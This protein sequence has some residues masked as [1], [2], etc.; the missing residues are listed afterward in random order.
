M[1][2][3]RAGARRSVAPVLTARGSRAEI[4]DRLIKEN[5][6][7]K[8]GGAVPGSPRGGTSPRAAVSPRA[9]ATPEKP[10]TA[11]SP[12]KKPAPLSASSAASNPPS[13]R[14]Q[15]GNAI[16]SLVSQQ[17]QTLSHVV[18]RVEQF[19]RAEQELLKEKE[20]LRQQVSDLSSQVGTEEAKRVEAQQKALAVQKELADKTVS[21]DSARAEW[22]A[23]KTALT[24]K[25]NAVLQKYAQK[26]K[27]LQTAT[28]EASQHRQRADEATAKLATLERGVKVLEGQK[29]EEDQKYKSLVAELEQRQLT[30]DAATARTAALEKEFQERLAAQ[31]QEAGQKE[32]GQ[33]R[34]IGEAE[35]ALATAQEEQRRLATALATAEQELAKLKAQPPVTDETQLK[36]LRR[37]DRENKKH[38]A[39]VVNKTMQVLG[40]IIERTSGGSSPLAEPRLRDTQRASAAADRTS[41][42]RR[43]GHGQSRRHRSAPGNGHR[44]EAEAEPRS[45]WEGGLAVAAAGPSGGLVEGSGGLTHADILQRVCAQLDLAS[46]KELIPF[47]I[48]ISNLLAFGTPQAPCR[49]SSS[50]FG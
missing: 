49:G 24:E 47:S 37:I 18:G 33:L 20:G 26:K 23:T 40:H 50:L 17:E 45:A 29:D 7:L 25:H 10:P 30:L 22:D 6:S 1:R 12:R 27:D 19:R 42:S 9:Q 31:R 4:I 15:S 13:A 8:K 28:A 38:N 34:R 5:D 11:I 21:F 32:V 3:T 16:Q 44:R 43:H 48:R 41:R 36:M 14:A 39:A 46:P 35:R 2:P